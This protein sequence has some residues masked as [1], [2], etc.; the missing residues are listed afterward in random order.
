[1]AAVFYILGGLVMLLGAAWFATV[2][3]QPL[4][5]GGAGMALIGKTLAATFPLS[6]MFA[7]LLLLAIG[8]VLSRLDRIAKN[9]ADAAVALEK[10][11]GAA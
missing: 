4:P 2:L 1:M 9:T 6:M 11:Q 7:G 10:I 5:V 3:G 8:G